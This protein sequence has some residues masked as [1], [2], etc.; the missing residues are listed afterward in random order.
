MKIYKHIELPNFIFSLN[1]IGVEVWNFMI[2]LLMIPFN[3]VKLYN[4]AQHTNMNNHQV[5]Y[6]TS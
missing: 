5:L 4:D 1:H 2:N 3:K 6:Q